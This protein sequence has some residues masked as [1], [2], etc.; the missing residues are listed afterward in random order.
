MLKRLRKRPR[1]AAYVISEAER[2]EAPQASLHTTRD[3]Y[4][5]RL[6]KPLNKQET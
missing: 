3:H 1:P 4:G 6:K 5:K 2:E